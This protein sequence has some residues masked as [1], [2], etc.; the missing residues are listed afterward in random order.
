[1]IRLHALMLATALVGF[2]IAGS[3]AHAAPSESMRKALESPVSVVFEKID[4]REVLDFVTTTFDINV[5]LDNR[6]TKDSTIEYVNLKNVTLA[7]GLKAILRPLGLAYSV[8]D[9]FIWVSTPE[10][11]RRETFEQLETRIFELPGPTLPDKNEAIHGTNPS[12][13]GEVKLEDLLRRATPMIV[14]PVNNELLSYFRY[15]L[16]T[17]QIVV[18]NTPT[19]LDRLQQLLDLLLNDPDRP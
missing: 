15:N 17:H 16:E 19:N 8:Q 1:M 6:V 13:V 12:A 3:G 9:R 7:E 18:H 4:L 11:I 10:N 5:V 14:D 2:G